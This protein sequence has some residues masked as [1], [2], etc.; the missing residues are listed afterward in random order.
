MTEDESPKVKVFHRAQGELE[1]AEKPI[2]LKYKK[3]K[4]NKNATAASDKE[5]YSSGLKDIQRLEGDVMKV[6]QRATKAISKGVDT[7]EDE[8]RKSA[9]DKR[10][11]AVED[12]FNNS[13]KAAS[14]FLKEASDIPVDI[15]ES[16]NKK[17]YRKR[18]R[19]G[20]RRASKMIRMWQI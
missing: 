14:A 12:F 5:R 6:A 16:V 2:V 1:A 4:K 17:S 8:R 11:G 3:R 18:L 9:G 19:K 20:L 13:A 15:A 10:D 7:Y